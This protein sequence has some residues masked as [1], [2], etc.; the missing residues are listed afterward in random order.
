MPHRSARG[1]AWS[2]NPPNHNAAA[3]NEISIVSH[4]HIEVVTDADP[5]PGGPEP[6]TTAWTD[7]DGYE[8]GESAPT[9]TVP[10]NRMAVT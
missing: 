7:S 10:S 9:P 3:D 5:P 2:P 6:P 8:I 1:V 4:E